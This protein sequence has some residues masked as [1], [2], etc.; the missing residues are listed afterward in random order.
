MSLL[1]PGCPALTV[2]TVLSEFHRTTHHCRSQASS[3]KTGTTDFTSLDFLLIQRW[4][5]VVCTCPE[6]WHNPR[7][8]GSSLQAKSI[9]C[10]VFCSLWW[11]QKKC[12]WSENCS[13]TSN[14]E[15]MFELLL[16]RIQQCVQ[17]K[18]SHNDAQHKN[19]WLHFKLSQVKPMWCFLL[20]GARLCHARGTV[21][22]W[23][24]FVRQKLVFSEC[25]LFK[26]QSQEIKLCKLT[27][28]QVKETRRRHFILWGV[29]MD[30]C[31]SVSWTGTS[32]HLSA[33]VQTTVEYFLLNSLDILLLPFWFHVSALSWLPCSH[34]V[35]CSIW[36]SQNN[37]PLQITGQFHDNR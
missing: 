33:G 29:E 13:L 31:F 17:I 5:V 37:P 14:K 22:F 20:P 3:K 24:I 15:I 32:F 34:S 12:Y 35:Y 10:Y 7:M 8:P 11:K 25:M 6:L 4:S 26:K 36:F 23:A 2:C 18:H 19:V 21:K 9:L 16:L 1:S 28:F 27:T 30:I